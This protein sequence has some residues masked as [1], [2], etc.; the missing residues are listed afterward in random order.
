VVLLDLH[1]DLLLIHP[2]FKH[3]ELQIVS[4]IQIFLFEFLVLNQFFFNF[5]YSF[6]C[7]AIS[8]LNFFFPAGAGSA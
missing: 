7:S 1:M 3:P 8:R 5:S 6:L 2:K 4:L